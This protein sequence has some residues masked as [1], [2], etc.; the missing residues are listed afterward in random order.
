MA[1]AAD[2]SSAEELLEWAEDHAT[3][4]AALCDE[5]SRSKPCEYIVEKSSVT[6]EYFHKLRLT[7]KLPVEI[8]LRT[9]DCINALRSALDHAIFSSFKALLGREPKNSKFPS[10]EDEKG[11]R[12]DA[13]RKMKEKERIDEILE[14][15]YKFQP[16]ND[17]DR[18]LYVLNK[19]RNEKNHQV[20]AESRPRLTSLTIRDGEFTIEGAFHGITF[21]K[22]IWNRS[23]SEL[24]I[25]RSGRPEIGLPEFEVDVVFGSNTVLSGNPV[26]PTLFTIHKKVDNVVSA[27]IAETN[28]LM[29]KR[30]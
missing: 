1:R 13:K 14:V 6:N 22:Q 23:K 12:A 5:F 15:A 20:L 11:V 16:W 19:I 9:F 21:G 3:A 4:I 28:R 8:Q 30:P 10:G 26:F 7:R 17:G 25:L 29:H 2:F 27:I 18:I 24:T